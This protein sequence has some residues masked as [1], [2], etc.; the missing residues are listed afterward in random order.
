L[1]IGSAILISTILGALIGFGISYIYFNT[2]IEIFQTQLSA[3]N[4]KFNDLNSTINTIDEEIYF[5]QDNLTITKNNLDNVRNDINNL[6]STVNNFESTLTVFQEDLTNLELNVSEATSAITDLNS[7]LENLD[8]AKWFTIESLTGTSD[9]YHRLQFKGEE[10]KIYW[11]MVGQS[12]S[13]WIEIKIYDSNGTLWQAAG[14]SGVYGVFE[15]E[16]DL[17][18]PGEYSIWI[19]VYDIN[20][21]KIEFLEYY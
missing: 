8:V 7:S 11:S 5:V 9:E 19:K 17:N 20:W 12:P 1:K 16:M 18:I 13:S 6:N 15:K 10:I 4:D 14:S 3:V 2:Q 21:W